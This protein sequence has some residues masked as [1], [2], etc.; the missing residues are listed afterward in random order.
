MSK[1]FYFTL[2]VSSIGL[3]HAAAG[4]IDRCHCISAEFSETF[5]IAV[6]HIINGTEAKK[7]SIPWMAGL[8]F[9]GGSRCGGSLL[10]VNER[11]ISDIVVTA[12]HCVQ[13][14]EGG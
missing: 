9:G 5:T 2:A 4:R 3:I 12:A 6:P 11:N 7:H 13:R 14:F 8:R 1:I 10:R